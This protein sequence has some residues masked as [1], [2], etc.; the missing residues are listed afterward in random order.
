M[1]AVYNFWKVYRGEKP[2]P[3]ALPP[4]G[5]PQQR[6]GKSVTLPGGKSAPL[7]SAAG[8][9]GMREN[10]GARRKPGRSPNGHRAF[11]PPGGK[12]TG[13]DGGEPRTAE[14]EP[15]AAPHPNDGRGGWLAN[16][17]RTHPARRPDHPAHRQ[18][19]QPDAYPAFRLRGSRRRFGGGAKPP[20]GFHAD[21]A[22]A[23]FWRPLFK[24]T[25]PRPCPPHRGAGR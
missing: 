2:V 15:K 14:A 20:G 3:G 25:A 6:G 9:R 21:G 17:T 18:Q 12:K 16:L 8:Y 23:A 4:G 13:K 1:A 11:L 7:P 19:R 22:V 10:M 24:K 5:C